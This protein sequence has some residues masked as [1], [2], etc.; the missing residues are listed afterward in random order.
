[1]QPSF[2]QPD[3]SSA[4]SA[5]QVDRRPFIW[6]EGLER[7]EDRVNGLVGCCSEVAAPDLLGVLIRIRDAHPPDTAARIWISSSCEMRVAR[8]SPSFTLTELTKTL[9]WGRMEPCSSR[10]RSRTPGCCAANLA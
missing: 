3:G 8:P 1:M 9:T 4:A 7:L 2:Q 6:K 10:V 5:S